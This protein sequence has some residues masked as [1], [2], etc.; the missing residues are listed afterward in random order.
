M[1]PLVENLRQVAAGLSGAVRDQDFPALNLIIAEALNWNS[2][3]ARLIPAQ[4]NFDSMYMTR[5]F[6]GPQPAAVFSVTTK[7]QSL[8]HIG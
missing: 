4:A 2:G 5:G 3:A 6:I 1:P 8:T 7:S